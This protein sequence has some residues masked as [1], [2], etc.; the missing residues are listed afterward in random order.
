MLA[1]EPDEGWLL[2]EDIGSRWIGSLP[3]ADRP[4]ALAAGARTLIEIQ[5]TMAE[6]PEDL[7]DL[8]AAGAQDRGLA[9][10]PGAFAA[11]LAA[12]GPDAP[13]LR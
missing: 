11:S 1:I 6:R 2:V 4:A 7:A 9:G 5:R 12:V 10:I 8:L 13:S 3:E